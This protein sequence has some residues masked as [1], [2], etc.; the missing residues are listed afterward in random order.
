MKIWKSYTVSLSSKLNYLFTKL[1]AVTFLNVAKLPSLFRKKVKCDYEVCSAC[2]YA[3]KQHT[4]CV[5]TVYCQLGTRIIS[6]GHLK[7][8][9]THTWQMQSRLHA[10]RWSRNVIDGMCC[11]SACVFASHPSV[12]FFLWQHPHR[13]YEFYFQIRLHFT[14]TIPL[15]F[16][17]TLFGLFNYST[18]SAALA[19]YYNYPLFICQPSERRHLCIY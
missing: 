16:S 12:Q 9:Y 2:L 17:N 15:F 7:N 14:K 13:K 5:H 6:R 4:V 1:A 10:R 18:C 19:L 11:E 3:R 8:T